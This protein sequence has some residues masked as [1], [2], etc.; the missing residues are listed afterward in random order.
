MTELSSNTANIVE[1]KTPFNIEYIKN[2]IAT[3]I[4]DTF[5]KQNENSQTTI[6]SVISKMLKYPFLKMLINNPEE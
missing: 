6:S 4:G 2:N 3:N 1:S 5:L